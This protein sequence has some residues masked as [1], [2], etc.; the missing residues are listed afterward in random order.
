MKRN[1]A[2]LERS[3][4]ALRDRLS[5]DHDALVAAAR[6][7]AIAV[8]A[9]P[10]NASLWREYR[11]AIATLI[12]VGADGD[13]DDDAAA[14]IGTLRTPTMSAQMGNSSHN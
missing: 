2:G 12:E 3:L 10:G 11:A 7:L 9:D 13:T 14:F 5:P 6:G 1:A 8:D 4:K